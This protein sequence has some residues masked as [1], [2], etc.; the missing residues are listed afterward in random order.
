[1][2][3]VIPEQTINVM[4]KTQTHRAQRLINKFSFIK[5]MNPM[6]YILMGDYTHDTHFSVL[7]ANHL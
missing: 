1:M 4:Q 6:G 3:L 5:A 7:R 2:S